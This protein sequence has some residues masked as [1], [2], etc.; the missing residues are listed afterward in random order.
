MKAIQNRHRQRRQANEEN[1]R[2]HDAVQ[3]DGLL[4][5]RLA[6]RKKCEKTNHLRGKDHAEHGNRSECRGQRPKQ[7]VCELPDFRAGFIRQV[8]GKNGDER[9]CHGPFANQPPKQAGNA[10]GHHK[11]VRC[12]SGTEQEGYAL[13][14]QIT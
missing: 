3:V 4:P 2:K 10:I 8:V 11:R 14:P 6:R 5:L 7:T 9:G 13:I 1:I 12:R